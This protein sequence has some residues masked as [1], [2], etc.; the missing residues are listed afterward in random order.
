MRYLVEEEQV[1]KFKYCPYCGDEIIDVHIGD[2]LGHTVCQN[3]ECGKGL[4]FSIFEEML[5]RYPQWIQKE[6]TN[7]ETEKTT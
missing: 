3:I 7:L 6:V 4:D 1:L 2:Y 5:C